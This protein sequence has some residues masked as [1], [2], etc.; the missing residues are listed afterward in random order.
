MSEEKSR[1][2]GTH[3]LHKNADAVVPAGW[4]RIVA[5]LVEFTGHLPATDLHQEVSPAYLLLVP[6]LAGCGRCP[7]GM[8]ITMYILVFVM[9]WQVIKEGTSLW[10]SCHESP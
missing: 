7:L 1:N 6:L 4:H 5:A 10:E 9:I 8:A 3:I 2:C